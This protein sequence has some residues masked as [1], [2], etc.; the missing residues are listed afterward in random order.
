M[1]KFLSLVL[2]LVVFITLFGQGQTVSAANNMYFN[3]AAI[4][5]GLNE[6]Y[7][8]KILNIPTIYKNTP[9]K[10]ESSNTEIATVSKTG[11]VTGKIQGEIKISATINKKV[12]KCFVSVFPSKSNLKEAAQKVEVKYLDTPTTLFCVFNNSSNINLDM[13]FKITFY[14]A[15]NTAISVR[16][17]NAKISTGDS[18]VSEIFK[19]DKDY[20]YYKI[21]YKNIYANVQKN[22]KTKISITPEINTYA[23]SPNGVSSNTSENVKL[24]D[25]IINNNGIDRYSVSPYVLY[26]KNDELVFVQSYGADN[27]YIKDIGESLFLNPLIANAMKEN[28]VFYMVKYNIPEYDNYKIIYDVYPLY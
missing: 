10:W 13:D 14:S 3:R 11:L 15:D 20:K 17:G 27:S 9:V 1:K 21:S 26:Y 6:S 19:S 5:V 24:V 16:E 7:Q 22:L 2:S 25:L 18:H 12:L 23:I 8:L 4:R 28:N